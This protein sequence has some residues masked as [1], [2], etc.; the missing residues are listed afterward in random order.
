MNNDDVLSQGSMVGWLWLRSV[1]CSFGLDFGYLQIWR[2]VQTVGKVV[3]L[4]NTLI[5]GIL[6]V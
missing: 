1:Q 4:E 6:F 2:S 5:K 3:N